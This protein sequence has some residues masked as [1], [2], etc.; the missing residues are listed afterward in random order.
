[1]TISTE[2]RRFP[3][4]HMAFYCYILECSDGT[5]YTGWSTDP[6]RRLREHNSGRG[7]RYTR[8]RRPVRLVYQEQ[9]PDK[10]AALKRERAIKALSRPKKIK[11]AGK[12][13]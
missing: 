13:G 2:I 8:S 11:L 10:R 9:L 5:Y 7:A 12:Q 6:Q 3:N 4:K 1:M